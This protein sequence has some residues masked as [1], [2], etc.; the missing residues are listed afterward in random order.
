M[1][2]EPACVK[3]QAGKEKDQWK[4]DESR[5]EVAEEL[6]ELHGGRLTTEDTESTEK[7]MRRKCS[8]STAMYFLLRVLCLLRGSTHFN[9]NHPEL[10]PSLGLIWDDEMAVARGVHRAPGVYPL[11]L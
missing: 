6:P 5:V 11:I 2:N 3:D 7:Q 10:N 9:H 1:E 4:L 8:S